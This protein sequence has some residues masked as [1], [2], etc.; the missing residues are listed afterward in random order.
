MSP[1]GLPDIHGVDGLLQADSL[2]PAR[3]P[4]PLNR[5]KHE[6]ARPI[7]LLAQQEVEEG[8]FVDVIVQVN[9]SIRGHG[10]VRF[11]RNA[12]YFLLPQSSNIKKRYE[13]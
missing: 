8:K 5:A 7:G 6:L 3:L 2:H 10:R 9:I 1:A 13:K 4:L 11:L 12:C